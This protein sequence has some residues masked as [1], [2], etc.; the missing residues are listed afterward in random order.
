M[1]TRNIFPLKVLNIVSVCNPKAVIFIP[2][3]DLNA[4]KNY[5]VVILSTA[6]ML[7][8]TGFNTMAGVQV[9]LI[10]Q[11]H[12]RDTFPTLCR[13][14]YL[15]LPP[16]RIAEVMLTDSTVMATFVLQSTTLSLLESHGLVHLWWRSKVQIDFKPFSHF[17][18]YTTLGM[19]GVFCLSFHLKNSWHNF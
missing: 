2:I 3:M 11:D 7:I 19:W 5:N 14:L 10:Y 4:R 8:F 13:L 9:D 17:Y 18:K 1:T 15:N 12:W 16:L 6:F